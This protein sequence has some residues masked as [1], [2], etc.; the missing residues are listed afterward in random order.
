MQG[1]PWIAG[2]MQKA[3]G[4]GSIEELVSKFRDLQISWVYNEVVY[5]Y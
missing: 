2:D 3:L 1:S 4:T 5:L